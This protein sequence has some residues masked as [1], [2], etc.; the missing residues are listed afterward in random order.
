MRESV[1]IALG[2]ITT[3]SWTLHSIDY[4]TAFL[5]GNA[6]NR[7]VYLKPPTECKTNKLWKLKKNSLW[8]GGC[9][10]NVVF[11]SKGRINEIWNEA[12]HI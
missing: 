5:Q 1:R 3:M 2:I 9:P 12:E 11:D 4:K 8:I 7:D 10:Q 6:I